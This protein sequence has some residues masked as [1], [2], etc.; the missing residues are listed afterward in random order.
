MQ[1]GRKILDH[2]LDHIQFK[3]QNSY[4]EIEYVIMD[5]YGVFSLDQ[6]LE[7]EYEKVVADID[8][9][10]CDMYLDERKAQ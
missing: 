2:Q 5:L 3:I 10:H 6:I 1:Y 9:L 8:G 7:S 4:N